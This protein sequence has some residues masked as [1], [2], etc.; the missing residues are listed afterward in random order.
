MSLRDYLFHAEPGITLYCGDC[1]VLRPMLE[2]EPIDAVV[3]DPPYGMAFNTDSTRF[4][5]G[6][7]QRGDGRVRRDEP[8]K[9]HPHSD[10]GDG[11]C[12]LLCGMS[13]GKT[14]DRKARGAVHAKTAF[15][16]MHHGYPPRR[17]GLGVLLPSRSV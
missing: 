9:N 4:S 11:L 2:G 8:V 5:G 6:E 7:Y 3:S 14:D 1:R 17:P 12:Y 13:P 10:H 15:N 16:P